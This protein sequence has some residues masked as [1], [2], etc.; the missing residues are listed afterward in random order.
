MNKLFAII[1]REY[2]ERVRT[3]MFLIA[4]VLGPALMVVLAVAPALLFRLQTGD[5][6][7]LAIVDETGRLYEPLRGAILRE[8]AATPSPTPVA[9][10]VIQSSSNPNGMTNRAE[11]IKQAQALTKVRYVVEEVP[12]NGRTLEAVKSELN[13]RII[14][15]QLDAYLVIPSDVLARSEAEFYG[16]NTGDLAT[17]K[18][19][20]NRINDV[21][22]EQR[23]IS[24]NID[25]SRV[26]ELL[27]GRA[28]LR[29]TKVSESGE[30]RDNGGGFLLAYGVG[31]AIYLLVIIYGGMVLSA[32]VEEKTTRISE[33]LFS[34]TGAFPLLLGKLLGVSLVA[35]TQ[36]GIWL[37]GF[38][39]FSI[40][41][42]LALAQSGT[43]MQFPTIAPIVYLYVI[44]YFLLGFFI[45]STIYALIGSMV[46]TTQE[47]Q[48][49]ATPVILL[50]MFSFF[51]AFTVIRAP[52]SPLAFWISM[53][54]F[55]SPINM[56]VRIV[57]ETP[58]FWQIALSLIIGY[59]TVIGLV[60]VAARIYRTGMLMYG[61]RASLA[62]ALRWVRQS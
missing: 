58:P 56:L 18:Q 14:A 59:A 54:P 5:A 43:V 19:L 60:W 61:K 21:L 39:F 35:L 44:L 46:T 55:F 47:G 22:L 12:V 23:F 17:L 24:A 27:R 13:A 50:L 42:V 33:V 49:L 53:I 26:R 25:A 34:S 7:R 30:Q 31:F 29:A 6:L 41:G 51:F 15:K 37:L 45:Y 3:K 16:R 28:E 32:V 20:E 48:Q 52:S 36:F 57:T 11:Q 38:A 9:A 10:T 1:R 40:Y 8:D 2:L 62:E 4:T